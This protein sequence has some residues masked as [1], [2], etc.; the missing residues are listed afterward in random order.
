MSSY[1]HRP[2]PR[3]RRAR[4]LASAGAAGL[5]LLA[6][7]CSS[8]DDRAEAAVPS[9]DKEV[10]GLCRGLDRALPET[11]VDED[12]SDPEPESELTAG[13]GS[14]AIILRCGIPRPPV[15][16]DPDAVT[17]E[18]DGVGW[19]VEE[20]EDGAHRFTTS[21]RRAYV[22]VALPGEVAAV[23]GSFALVDLAPAIKRT[24]PQG[25]AD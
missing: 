15:M 9:P 23:S 22:E 10:T 19:V 1:R 17:V 3:A 12:R 11:V 21:L 2:R 24:I 4:P 7:A 13:W 14:P 16:N 20:L 25:V 6:A 5:V 18:V 8:A